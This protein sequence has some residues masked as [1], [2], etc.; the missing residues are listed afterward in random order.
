M[1]Q[2]PN[3]AEPLNGRGHELIS[4]LKDAGISFE[5]GLSEDEVAALQGIFGFR[6]PPDLKCL[7][8]CAMP[9]GEKFPNWRG[10]QTQLEITLGW[11]M[12]GL[13]FDVEHNKFWIESWRSRPA[14]TEDALTLVRKL[15]RE[16]PRLVPIY[17]HRFIPD[18]PMLVGNP[19]FSVHQSDIIVYGNDLPSY[20]QREFGI[21]LP[22][23]ATKTKRAIRFWDV[24]VDFNN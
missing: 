14:N 10:S 7:L 5:H 20:F 16:A 24:I 1:L 8:Q 11:P 3:S 9:V 13:C 2:G 18:E 23:W 4:A 6:F 19:V 17:M 21:H 12:E 15:C 22:M